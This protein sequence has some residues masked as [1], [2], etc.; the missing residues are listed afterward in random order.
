MSTFF[1]LLFL[2]S[3]LCLFVGLFKLRVFPKSLGKISLKQIGLVFC[4]GTLVFL[5]LGVAAC[6]EQGTNSSTNA[7]GSSF[8]TQTQPSVE[9]KI[10]KETIGVPFQTSNENDPTLPQGQTKVKQ[11]GKNGTQE[12]VYQVTYANGAE[13]NRVELSENV[14]VQPVAQIISVG[15]YVPPAPTPPSN[16]GGSGYQNSSGN[17]VPS[18][19][20]N[21]DGATARCN[22]GTY[23]YSQHRQGTCSHHGGVAEWL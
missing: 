3:A 9:T 18:P 21:P 23:S 8:T 17:Y 1:F 20:S 19:G 22:D 10:V 11:E 6:S 12:I 13:T 14:T 4:I 16:S 5:I 15:T 7:F 2:V